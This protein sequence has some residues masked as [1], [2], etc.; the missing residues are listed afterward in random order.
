[1]NVDDKMINLEA[2]IREIEGELKTCVNEEQRTADKKRLAALE[3]QK[4]LLLRES[5]SMPSVP[6]S[7]NFCGFCSVVLDDVGH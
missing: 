4:T 5:K 1:M 7:C 2:K 6:E 3:E